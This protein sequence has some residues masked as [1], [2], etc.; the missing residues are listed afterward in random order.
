MKP[1]KCADDN[2]KIVKRVY[3]WDGKLIEIDL[4]KMHLSD[5]DFQDFVA[6]YQ[7]QGVITN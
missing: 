6:E 5:P 2:L 7:I 4:C 3:D 1:R